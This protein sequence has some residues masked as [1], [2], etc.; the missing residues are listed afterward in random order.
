MSAR[1]FLVIRNTEDGGVFV[2][3][4]SEP[5]LVRALGDGLNVLT[6][7]DVAMGRMV[8]FG[9]TGPRGALIF[10]VGALVQPKS[11]QVVTQWVIP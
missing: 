1:N 8:D 6:L 10:P 4:V 2:E 11:Q 3:V 5:D 7:A 9:N